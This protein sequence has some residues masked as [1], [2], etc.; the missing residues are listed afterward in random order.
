MFHGFETHRK[1]KLRSKNLRD[2]LCDFCLIRSVVLKTKLTTG[3][4]L[5]KP[6]EIL[7]SSPINTDLHSTSILLNFI[8]GG[9]TKSYEKFNYTIATKLTC[10]ICTRDQCLTNNFMINLD[11]ENH[12]CCIE[13]LLSIKTQEAKKNHTCIPNIKTTDFF[14]IKD[15]EVC[16]FQSSSGIEIHLNKEYEFGG[17]RWQCTCAITNTKSIFKENEVWSFTEG[18]TL[19]K[20]LRKYEV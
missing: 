6:I 18:K 2:L 9:M 16:I 11:F 7:C 5:I 10:I 15:S 3:R 14:V 1:C 20:I 17:Y 13:E 8:L 19:K 4:Q 12:S